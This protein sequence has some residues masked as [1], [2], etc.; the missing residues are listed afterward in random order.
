MSEAHQFPVIQ[1]F[2]SPEIADMR[3]IEKATLS[4]CL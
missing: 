3:D 4:D 2:D 1:K